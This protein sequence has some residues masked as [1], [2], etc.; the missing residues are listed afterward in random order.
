MLTVVVPGPIRG[1]ARPRFTRTGHAF[2][3]AT[4]VSA[5]NWV[6]ACA[7]DQV[8]TPVLDGP[9]ALRVDVTVQIPASW[10]RRRRQDALEGRLRP[11]GKPDADNV[12]K[13]IGDALNGVVWKDDAQLVEVTLVKRYADAPGATLTIQE[14]A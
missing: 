2:T 7:V 8:G 12:L 14:A 4:T 13:L 3:P 9:L 1:K 10:P 6:R 11:T 5:E